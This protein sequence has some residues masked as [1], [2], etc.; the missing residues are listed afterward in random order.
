MSAFGGKADMT[1]CGCLLLRSLLG[2]KR[3]WARA[4]HMSAF[5]PKRTKYLFRPRVHLLRF[6]KK[7]IGLVGGWFAQAR[8]HQS[9]GWLGI[10]LAVH[11]ASAAA[12]DASRRISGRRKPGAVWSPLERLPPRPERNGL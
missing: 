4:V 5:D 1:F 10:A 7:T 8:F 12:D 9:R 3:T 2:V 6:G 11:R